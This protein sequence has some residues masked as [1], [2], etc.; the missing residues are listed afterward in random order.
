[1]YI[2]W[3]V[4]NCVE[5][6]LRTK[7]KKKF[8]SLSTHFWW[9]DITKNMISSQFAFF[10]WQKYIKD[11]AWQPSK[12]RITLLQELPAGSTMHLSTAPQGAPQ[13]AADK[14]RRRTSPAQSAPSAPSAGRGCGPAG[15]G[16]CQEPYLWAQPAGP[17]A[18]RSQVLQHRPQGAH[19]ARPPA[20]IP[21]SGTRFTQ[22]AHSKPNRSK[23]TV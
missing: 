20:C 18:P 16:A 11:C 4:Q 17:C 5:Q 15:W 22:A 13:G 9:R 12:F 10:F 19:L 23:C 21:L 1:M 6:N 7:K 8:Y 2:I 3:A 14:G